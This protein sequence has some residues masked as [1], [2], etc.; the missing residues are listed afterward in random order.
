MELVFPTVKNLETLLP[1]G[2]SEEV[3]EA[4]RRGE[5]DQ[6]VRVEAHRDGLRRDPARPRQ[7]LGLIVELDPGLLGQLPAR[8]SS[9]LLPGLD[10][11]AR[12]DPDARHE[13]CA[14]S[15]PDHQHLGSAV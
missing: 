7:D 13:R 11:A 4:V 5:C 1:Y 6:E 12:E 3:I 9:R 2:R 10:H 8:R 15:A 14:G